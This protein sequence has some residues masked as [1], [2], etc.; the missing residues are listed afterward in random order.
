[1]SRHEKPI[2]HVSSVYEVDEA[3][4]KYKRVLCPPE[5]FSMLRQAGPR[6]V[7]SLWPQGVIGVRLED[8]HKFLTPQW[9]YAHR[10][11]MFSD[12]TGASHSAVLALGSSAKYPPFLGVQ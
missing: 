2:V 1:M 12:V 5:V 9:Q 4:R 8:V 6:F 3:V 7:T 10:Y 11:Y